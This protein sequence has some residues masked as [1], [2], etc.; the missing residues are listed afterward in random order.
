MP[1]SGAKAIYPARPGI[2]LPVTMAAT[3]ERKVRLFNHEAL[4][5]EGHC[6]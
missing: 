5:V 2:S 6:R 1:P 4:M 3:G